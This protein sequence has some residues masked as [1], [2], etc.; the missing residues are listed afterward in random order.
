VALPPLHIQGMHGM[1]D[2]LHQ[3]AVLRQ[4]MQRYDVTLETSWPSMYH[5]LIANGLKVTRRGVGLRTQTKNAS[6][7]SESA[8]YSPRH[9]FTRAAL[10]ISYHGQQVLSTPSKT[11]LEVMCNVT[12]TSY[13]DA[14]YR[15]PVPAEWGRSLYKALGTL[16]QISRER[17]WMFYRP[18]VARPE[19]RGSMARNADETAYHDLF[20]SIRDQFF[21][22]SVAD[23][24]PGVE[25]IVGPDAKADLSFHRGELVFEAIAALAQQSDLV[26]TSSGFAA[27]LGPAVE[28]PTI[29]I[30]GGYE[31]VRC[32]DSGK[33]FSPYL[34]IG[35][36]DNCSCWTSS[37]GRICNK[38][39]DI[40][41]A[42]AAISRFI[43]ETSPCAP[44]LPK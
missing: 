20:N 35:P 23:L 32:H 19:W 28:T 39:I 16:P 38:E 14:D 40:D 43:A 21:V 10:R 42:R 8:L 22:V 33:K 29:S 1:G 24:V 12:G 2:C 7:E 44:V 15:L 9:S 31:D 6:R 41:A 11:I 27:V 18:L 4:L 37:C 36:K 30:I 13:A 17:P 25:W 26:F 34:A 5:D 3:R